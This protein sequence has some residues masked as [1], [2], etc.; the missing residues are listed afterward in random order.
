MD[1]A[2]YGITASEEQSQSL[3]RGRYMNIDGKVA[4][5]ADEAERQKM[6][7]GKEFKRE[8]QI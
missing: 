2:L 5:T 4:I 8:K 7:Q 6:R 1:L 3:K